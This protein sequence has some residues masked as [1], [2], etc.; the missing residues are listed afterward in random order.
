VLR[1]KVPGRKSKVLYSPDTAKNPGIR[2]LIE[3]Q[4][5]CDLGMR[6][7]FKTVPAMA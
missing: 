6:I 5:S 1:P 4:E 7:C 3:A 2:Y